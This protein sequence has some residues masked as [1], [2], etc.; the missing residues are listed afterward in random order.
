MFLDYLLMTGTWGCKTFTPMKYDLLV[1][2]SGNRQP[3]FSNCEVESIGSFYVTIRQSSE[4]RLGFLL[5]SLLY[6][7]Y[8]FELVQSIDK[9]SYV[10][11]IECFISRLETPS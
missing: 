5:T 8:H 1:E 3:P 9:N 6:S 10:M 7:A 2:R 4:K 11:A